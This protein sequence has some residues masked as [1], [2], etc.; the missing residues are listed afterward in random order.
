MLFRSRQSTV[1]L[2]AD[3][4]MVAK[5]WRGQLVGGYEL[6]VIAR[7][8]TARYTDQGY[9]GSGVVLADQTIGSG[10]VVFAAREVKLS[11]IVMPHHRA[12]CGR[13]PSSNSSGR[14]DRACCTCRHCRIVSP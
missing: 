8:L 13:R 1:L 3:V 12:G 5:R 7:E 6:L 4:E 2:P 14:I 10:V 11:T 9:A